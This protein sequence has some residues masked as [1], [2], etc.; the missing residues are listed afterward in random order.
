LA[1]SIG[2]QGTAV[3]ICRS[4]EILFASAGFCL[5]IGSGEILFASA[6]FCFRY[7]KKKEKKKKQKEKKRF[8][9]YIYN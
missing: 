9:I 8:I 3:G 5:G 2:R 6:E 1:A 7:R 4:G